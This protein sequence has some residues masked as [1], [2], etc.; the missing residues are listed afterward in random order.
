M[1]CG[2]YIL[3]TLISQN[4]LDEVSKK[5][6]LFKDSLKKLMQKHA[7]IADVRGRGLLIGVELNG[8]DGKAV[9]AKALENGFILNCA[10]HN[11]LRLA[12]P[13]I[14]TY[15]EIDALIQTLDRILTELS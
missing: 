14:I 6:G 4:L 11:T 2:N 7:C 12:P 10:G 5:G 13:F 3:D 8:V 1:R 9:V 15:K